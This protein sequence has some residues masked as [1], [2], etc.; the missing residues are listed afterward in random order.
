MGTTFGGFTEKLASKYG[1]KVAI[2]FR[3]EELTYRDLDN[4]SDRIMLFYLGNGVSKGTHV[5]L[6]ASNSA[7]WVIHYLALC[8]LG[9]VAVL[10]NTHLTG[11]EL[12]N[13]LNYADVT[14][15]TCGDRAEKSEFKVCLDKINRESAPMLKRIFHIGHELGSLLMNYKEPSE[16]EAE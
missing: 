6:L 16:L 13:A 2:V 1:D 12:A 10:F 14:Y 3:G 9:A 8:K 15:L 7:E 5:G 11:E 4:F